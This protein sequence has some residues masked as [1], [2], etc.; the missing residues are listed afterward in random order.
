MD[1]PETHEL[2]AHFAD[3]VAQRAWGTV[4]LEQVP[5]FFE[6]VGSRRSHSSTVNGI[7]EQSMELV[8]CKFGV[9]RLV[10]RYH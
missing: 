6:G 2:I 9:V 1:D 4:V 7:F 8:S 5:A 3:L 10:T